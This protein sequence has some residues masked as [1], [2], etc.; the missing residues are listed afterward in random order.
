VLI[1]IIVDN[2]HWVLIIVDVH[3]RSLLFYD[4]FGGGVTGVLDTVRRWLRD[5]VVHRQGQEVEVGWGIE[6]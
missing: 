5:E 1:P 2:L 3:Q 4:S 6:S